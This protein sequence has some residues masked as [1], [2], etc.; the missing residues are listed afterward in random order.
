MLPRAGAIISGQGMLWSSLVHDAVVG[1][2][3]EKITIAI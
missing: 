1:Y 2:V 3:L